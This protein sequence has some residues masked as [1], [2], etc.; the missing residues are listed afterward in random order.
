M[1]DRPKV[2][3]SVTP[4]LFKGWYRAPELLPTTTQY[5]TAVDMWAMGCI[6]GNLLDGKPMFL[7]DSDLDQLH[8]IQKMMSTMMPER[9]EF[10]MKTGHSR[11]SRRQTSLIQRHLIA[12]TL[13]MPQNVPYNS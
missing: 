9:K 7:G 11:E 10:Y 1:A 6:M 5:S 3:V 12:S 13:D 8:V 2:P 4:Q